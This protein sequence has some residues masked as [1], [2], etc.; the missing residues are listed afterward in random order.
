MTDITIA[1]SEPAFT[2]LFEQLRDSFSESASD[3]GSFGPFTASYAVAF[4]LE[5]GS[6]D[7][8]GDNTVRIGELDVVWDTLA[9]SLGLD[10]P[11]VCVGGWCIV[12][13]PFGGAVRLPRKCFFQGNPDVSIP[14]DLSGLLRSEISLIAGLRTGYFV[15]PGRQSWMDYIDAEN[16]GVPNKWQ[17]FIDPESVDIDV[18]DIADIIGDLLE[19]AIDAAVDT[20]LGF[21]PGWAR[22]ST[23]SGR[24]STCPTTSRSGSRTC[25]APASASSTSSSRRSW[26]TSSPNRSSSSRTPTPS[27]TPRAASSRSRSR[28]PTS[29]STSPTTRWSSRPT[30]ARKEHSHD[31][32]EPL[33]PDRPRQ[34]R[35]DPARVSGAPRT[36]ARR[37]PRRGARRRTAGRRLRLRGGEAG[38]AAARRRRRGTR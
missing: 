31:Q 36:R 33:H 27:S 8:R 23:S 25:W 16:A 7:L 37:V 10:I 11:S 24:S 26:T 34:W 32:H 35:P 21:L 3:S 14:L 17:V 19:D 2:A 9:V 13:T 18:F 1:A 12:P 28:S 29:T 4:H 30:S 22:S 15:D 6:V 38:P 20:L 5:N